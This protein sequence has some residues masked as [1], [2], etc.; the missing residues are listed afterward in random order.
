[1]VRHV[2]IV[3]F[4]LVYA[5]DTDDISYCHHRR[6]AVI[7]VT[8]THERRRCTHINLDAISF[9]FGWGCQWPNKLKLTISVIKKIHF[10]SFL[11]FC[12]FVFCPSSTWSQSVSS[13]QQHSAASLIQSKRHVKILGRV[14][15]A[16]KLLS[17]DDL[18]RWLVFGGQLPSVSPWVARK[19]SISLGNFLLDWICQ[20]QVQKQFCKYIRSD[21][22]FAALAG[23][24]WYGEL[25]LPNSP[26]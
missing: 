13:R 7:G 26:A 20:K 9:F 5:A 23:D 15:Q 8:A 10:D 11:S 25:L 6:C 1:M 19:G 12:E 22:H 4:E 24:L 14:N 18:V 21:S 2:E 16:S 17:D 3:I